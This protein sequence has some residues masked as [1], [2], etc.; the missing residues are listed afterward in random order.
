MYN[1]A[2]LEMDYWL[3]LKA[4]ENE[5]VNKL[6]LK[7]LALRLLGNMGY[8]IDRRVVLVRTNTRLDYGFLLKPLKGSAFS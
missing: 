7:G 3:K 1:L 2:R 5:A 8:S 6:Y 4:K